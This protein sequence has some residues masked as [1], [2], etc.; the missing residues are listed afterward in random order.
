MTKLFNIYITKAL[1]K[2]NSA[3]L[4]P[5]YILLDGVYIYAYAALRRSSR[6]TARIIALDNIY[7]D[8]DDCTGSFHSAICLRRA[9]FTVLQKQMSRRL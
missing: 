1:I 4:R 6:L 2:I 3:P 5:Q 8:N 7:M 9:Y